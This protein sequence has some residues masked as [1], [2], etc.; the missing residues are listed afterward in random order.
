MIAMK[1]FKAIWHIFIIVYYKLAYYTGFVLDETYYVSTARQWMEINQYKK[2]IK[3]LEKAK[4]E[5][6][7]SYVRYY[8][9]WCYQHVLEF[10]KALV[11]YEKAYEKQKQPIYLIYQAYCKF[12]LNQTDDATHIL[13]SLKRNELEPPELKELERIEDIIKSNSLKSRLL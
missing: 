5:Y 7:V 4:K 12:A 6:D 8:L 2:A 10:E 3:Y 9:G 1:Y 11:N 13:N